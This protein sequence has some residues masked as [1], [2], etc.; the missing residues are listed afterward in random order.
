[1]IRLSDQYHPGVLAQ[2]IA[3]HLDYYAPHW[4]FGRQFEAGVAAGMGEFFGRFDAQRDLFLAAYNDQDEL[5]GSL[6]ID[7]Q[8]AA[9]E[10]A[11]LRWFIVAESARGQG[12]GHQLMQR[13][14]AFLRQQQYP[15]TY[16]TTFAGL[17]AARA[18][19]QHYGFQLVAEQS[20]DPWSGAVGMQRYERR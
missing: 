14:D 20:A 19:Y 1:M 11:H 9:G 10:G 6:T 18:L 17:D 13:A 4:G 2:V 5:V 12:L 8:D 7:G 15:R 16:L 3:L